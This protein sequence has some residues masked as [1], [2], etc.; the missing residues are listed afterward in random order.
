MQFDKASAGQGCEACEEEPTPKAGEVED[1]E[2]TMEDTWGSD[3]EG[4][5]LLTPQWLQ[6]HYLRPHLPTPRKDPWRLL[7]DHAMCLCLLHTALYQQLV[8]LF[9][10]NTCLTHLGSNTNTT[11]AP[12]TLRYTPASCGTHWVT[13]G[14]T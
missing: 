9:C 5:S 3:G 6:S 8:L 14:L 4:G 13:A 1:K 12:H 7:K 2:E 10:Q 11:P